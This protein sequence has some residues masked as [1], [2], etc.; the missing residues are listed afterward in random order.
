MDILSNILSKHPME[1]GVPFRERANQ[2]WSLTPKE[3]SMC[4]IGQV[5]RQQDSIMSNGMEM[6]MVTT[7]IEESNHRHRGTGVGMTVHD[8]T[9]H[10]VWNGGSSSTNGVD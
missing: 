9:I 3:S 1:F 10:I 6:K 8:G 2:S 7:A 5:M 4:C